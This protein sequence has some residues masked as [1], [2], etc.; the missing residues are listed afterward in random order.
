MTMAT[1]IRGNIQLGLAYSSRALVHYR[2][3]E[4]HG[5][6]QEDME[7]KEMIVIHLDPQATGDVCHTGHSLNI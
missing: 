5:G 6:A 1:L 4:K 2:H 3:G 7:L